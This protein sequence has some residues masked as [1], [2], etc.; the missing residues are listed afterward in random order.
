MYMCR[1][2]VDP[3][4]SS[5]SMKSSS[6]PPTHPHWT[7]GPIASERR[8]DAHSRGVGDVVIGAWV[9]LHRK[10]GSL[11]PTVSEEAAWAPGSLAGVGGRGRLKVSG[12][13]N[14]K[15]CS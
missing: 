6:D 13:D 1:P 5:S 14:T 3:V 7:L 11:A 8:L 4:Q 15:I 9:Y 12:R 2:I 10:R